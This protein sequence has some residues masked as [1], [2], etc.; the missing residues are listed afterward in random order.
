ML[1]YFTSGKLPKAF[2]ILPSLRN[3]EQLLYLTR[4]D[5]WTHVVTRMATFL[6]SRG[7]SDKLVQRFYYVILFP[8]I[9]EEIQST[10]KLNFHYYLALKVLQNHT[11]DT[12]IHCSLL[13]IFFSFFL[14]LISFVLLHRNLS[15]DQQHSSEVS[16]YLS[17]NQE[18]ALFAR[19]PSLDP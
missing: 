18:T 16:C 10:R 8:K 3:W 17:A 5:K 13:S 15:T 14:F 2:K 7:M 12:L 9:R 11:T 1:K 4:P 19:P 6:F